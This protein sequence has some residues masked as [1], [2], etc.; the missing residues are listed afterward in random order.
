MTQPLQ[1]LTFTAS[2]GSCA[3][4]IAT[5]FLSNLGARPCSRGDVDKADLAVSDGALPVLP[6]ATLA[7]LPSLT[8][9][10]VPPGTLDY[11]IGL[12][13]A[14]TAAAA[15]YAGTVLELDGA[16]V[17]AHVFLPVLLATGKPDHVWPRPPPPL[18]VPGGALSCELGAD[19]DAEAFARLCETMEARSCRAEEIAK[20]AQEW[21]LP[22]VAYRPRT[23]L[24]RNA[25]CAPVVHGVKWGLR[26]R[27]E[28]RARRY[29]LSPALDARP[30]LDGARVTDLTSMWA[31][32]LA[33]WW[34]A[35]LGADVRKVEAECRVDGMRSDPSAFL[36]LN[37]NKRSLLLD[38]REKAAQRQ[39]QHHL[40]TSDLLVSSFSPRVLPNFDMSP[41]SLVR[42]HPELVI[43][44]IPAFPPGSYRRHW[45]SYGGGVH[46]A[47]GLGDL[48]AGEFAAPAV[49]YSDPVGGIAAFATSCAL[50]LGRA[51]GWSPR[52]AE[53][54][55]LS[56]VKPLL[57]SPRS[58]WTATPEFVS[59]A[60]TKLVERGIFPPAQGV[61]PGAPFRGAGLPVRE[62][63]PV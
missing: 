18:M 58:R 46:A 6:G 31:G 9:P 16:L 25:P 33:T 54:P 42:Q 36:S 19:G 28:R 30:P 51:R 3:V 61:G 37:R 20:L 44:A 14:G 35:A 4:R 59:A 47:S 49:T 57:N 2:G 50:L 32:P 27:A 29:R 1:G 26:S 43:V 8:L 48:G 22:V 53:V 10:G 52:P 21:R 23:R 5:W 41:R 60:V 39:L 15:A 13:L 7:P 11:A 17:A 40:T 56:A 55:L 24:N 62:V 63:L 45:V 34:L 38:L 12:A